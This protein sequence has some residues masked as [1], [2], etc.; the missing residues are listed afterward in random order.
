MIQ[1]APMKAMNLFTAA[2][3]ALL[4]SEPDEKVRLTHAL[5]AAWLAGDLACIGLL[6]GFLAIGLQVSRL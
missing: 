5:R 6:R 1:S 3:Q 2:Y 4:A